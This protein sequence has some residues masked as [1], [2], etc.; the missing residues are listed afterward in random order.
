MR[1]T[2][3]VLLFFLLVEYLLLPSIAGVRRSASLL[4]HAHVG[5]VLTGALLEA[6]AILAHARL[7]RDVLPG[8]S[9]PNLWTVLRADLATLSVR[10]LVPGGAERSAVGYRLLG[11]IGLERS[12]TAVALATQR[13]GSAVV[14]TILLGIGLVVSIPLR[15]LNSLYG[16]AAAAGV[17]V[18]GGFGV[19][20]LLLVKGEPRA[21]RVM[22]AAVRRAPFLQKRTAPRLLHRLAA[23]LRGLIADRRMLYSAIGWAAASW[24]LD[25]ASLWVFVLAYGGRVE[26]DALLVSYGLA[27]VI[28]ALPLTPGGLGYVEAVVT[29]SLVG[30]GTPLGTAILGVITW[31]LLNF[32][33]PIPAGG[34]AYLS[35]RARTG[36]PMRERL[37]ELMRLVQES[38]IA[39]DRPKEWLERHGFTS[40]HNRE[41]GAVDR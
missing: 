6:A 22:R 36:A 15:G 32:W 3:G 1:R 16:T 35:L 20:M 2:A 7:T 28:A 5:F 21:G 12:D 11:Q 4:A 37:K 39:A 17:L 40:T 34:L 38:V 30:F 9:R 25:A 14:L 33:F 31:R 19:L 24:L 8:G 41:D 29:L 27:N 18:I 13:I 23:R 26:I 10:H